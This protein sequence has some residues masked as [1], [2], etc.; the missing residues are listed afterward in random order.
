MNARR[1]L[2]T[3]PAA[4]AAILA[5]VLLLGVVVLPGPSLAAPADHGE[6]SAP[7]DVLVTILPHASLVERLGG[8]AVRVHVLIGPQETPHTFDPT[9]R[10]LQR[11]SAAEVWFTTGVALE[12]A[13]VPR[14]QAA[15]PGLQVVPTHES[16]ELM[17]AAGD[18]HAGHDHAGHDHAGHDC[19]GAHDADP[20]VW[21]S[22]RNTARQ[23]DVMARTLQDLLPA[24]ADAIADRAARLAD[25]IATLDQDLATLLEPVRGRT[26]L[27]FHPAF[28]YFARD[29][30][31]VQKAI[32]AGGL[33]P[34]PRRLAELMREVEDA[35]VGTVFVQP[36][37]SDQAAR[38]LAQEAGLTVT[39]LD[40]LAR[41]HLANLWRIGQAVRAGLE[42][43]P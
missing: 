15:V 34:G 14:L 41:D 30:G 20:H 37:A 7:L 19:A 18:D 6:R 26:M 11:L 22:P 5:G 35:G 10:E 43:S 33:A 29:H 2:A 38:T 13:L 12:A 24:H 42:V 25:D 40:P 9:P 28:G 8:D 31:L 39:V 36:Q 1:F 16:L 32:E 4:M 23:A 3:P 17:P 21:L 27:V